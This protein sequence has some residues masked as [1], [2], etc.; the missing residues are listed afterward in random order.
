MY[1]AAFHTFETDSLIERY[2]A[3]FGIAS[4][5]TVICMQSMCLEATVQLLHVVGC[6][7]CRMHILLKLNY[8]KFVLHRKSPNS[9][10]FVTIY[11]DKIPDNWLFNLKT[12]CAA[13][14]LVRKLALLIPDIADYAVHSHYLCN[15]SG[16]NL[17]KVLNIHCIVNSLGVVSMVRSYIVRKNCRKAGRF[18]CW[19]FFLPVQNYQNQSQNILIVNN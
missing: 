5:L 13:I 16:L 4:R 3:C 7:E 10:Q 15:T 11:V 14:P 6:Y 17:T 12:A 1:Q 8:L 9:K 19:K 18:H 2:F